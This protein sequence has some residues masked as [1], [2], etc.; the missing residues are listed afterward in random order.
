MHFD[1]FE[2]RRV[3]YLPPS[4]TNS[5]QFVLFFHQFK[6]MLNSQFGINTVY[7][8]ALFLSIKRQ[9]F[10]LEPTEAFNVWSDYVHKLQ[11]N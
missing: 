3:I 11:Q 7:Y 6:K 4:V 10:V 8:A 1:K 2:T 9:E 5:K